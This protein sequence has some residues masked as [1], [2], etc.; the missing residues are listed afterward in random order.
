MIQKAAGGDQHVA[1]TRILHR[2]EPD[3]LMTQVRATGHNSPALPDILDVHNLPGC[4]LL[5]VLVWQSCTTNID[6]NSLIIRVHDPCWMLQQCKGTL[7]LSFLGNH[8][9]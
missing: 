5:Y 7:E 3:M 8:F 1:F 2:S 9:L 4:T 6:I